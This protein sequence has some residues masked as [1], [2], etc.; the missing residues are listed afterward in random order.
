MAL[1]S[2]LILRRVDTD[3]V[4][5]TAVIKVLQVSYPHSHNA[6]I[7]AR[8]SPTVCGTWVQLVTAQEMFKD[9][10]V[11][12]D[13]LSDDLH[14]R[15]PPGSLDSTHSS[16]DHFGPNF[17]S[18]TDAKRR[19]LSSHRLDLPAQ[20]PGAAW[21]RGHFSHWD[22]EGDLLSA[23]PT[24]GLASP[25]LPTPATSPEQ[26]VVI[27]APLS[28]TEEEMFRVLCSDPEWETP[29]TDASAM[30]RSEGIVEP[31]VAATDPVASDK[32]S[33]RRPL[34]R[35]KRVANAIANRSR[36][37]SSKRGSRSSLS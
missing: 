37:R 21:E 9:H 18:T 34:R 33:T 30:D 25:M 4:N 7:V 20:E 24:F 13:F 17:Q 29:N 35:S 12:S 32:T 2:S 14:V 10:H 19:S 3:F 16:R 15:F 26:E 11:L 23:H 5:V 1:G 22:L 8:G 27:E 31:P 6:V 36:T 28:P